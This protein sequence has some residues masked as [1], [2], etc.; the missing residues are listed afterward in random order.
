MS[1]AGCRG[2]RHDADYALTPSAAAARCCRRPR[3]LLDFFEALRGNRPRWVPGPLGELLRRRPTC[4]SRIGACA[5]QDHVAASLRRLEI[6]PARLVSPESVGAAAARSARPRIDRAVGAVLE[7]PGSRMSGWRCVG[8]GVAR[9][10][11]PPMRSECTARE[12]SRTPF[13]GMPMR[14]TPQSSREPQPS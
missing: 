8:R 9:R 13:A 1:W 14:F 4:A 11:H 10:S 5:A 12:Q 7:A 6:P 3:S 2:L